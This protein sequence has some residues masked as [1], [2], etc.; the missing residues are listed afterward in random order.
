MSAPA[1][2]APLTDAQLTA[3]YAAG[4]LLAALR[5]P[6]DTA[7]QAAYHAQLAS[8][9]NDGSI[10]LLELT[11]SQAFQDLDKRQYFLVLQV[12][13]GVIPL[14]QAETR[15]VH[16]AVQRFL[17]HECRDGF[18]SMAADA[19]RSWMS[20]DSARARDVLAMAKT[21]PASDLE[22]LRAALTT[23]GDIAEVNAVLA[24][25]DQRRRAAIAALGGIKPANTAD[26]NAAL[27]KLQ[28]IAGDDPDQDMRFTAIFAAFGLLALEPALARKWVPTFVAAVEAKPSSQVR[29]AL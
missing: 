7:H 6:Q 18:A 16:A 12:Y 28:K 3:S 27:A 29:T 21:D 19:F 20:Q 10:D 17:A 24:M 11:G 9:H 13:L 25:G 26:A 8:L 22:L 15:A 14:L 23:L 1:T 4:S 2:A 5:N